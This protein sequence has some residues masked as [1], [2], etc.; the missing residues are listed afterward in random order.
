MD[1]MM[2]MVDSLL[3]AK[4]GR[5]RKS[6]VGQEI[7]AEY[8]EDGIA[9]RVSKEFGTKE[10]LAKYL[11]DH[12]RANPSRHK[13]K[14]G[15]DKKTKKEDSA[16]SKIHRM[17][18]PKKAKEFKEAEAEQIRQDL[19][20][21]EAKKRAAIEAELKNFEGEIQEKAN[22]AMATGGAAGFAAYFAS[23]VAAMAAVGQVG[24]GA[25]VAIPVIAGVL[26][27]AVVA[28][29]G[30]AAVGKT[31]SKAFGKRAIQQKKEELGVDKQASRVN[32]IAT[33]I[34]ADFVE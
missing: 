28:M 26:G 13:V 25:A 7:A 33:R 12:P 2:S 22:S 4:P 15:P 19:A 24:G 30:G 29:A 11:K 18:S 34:I 3:K 14:G 16:L 17:I 31:I 10:E 21:A 8:R 1:N 5:A 23:T 20:A 9:L 32:R 27:G 6:S